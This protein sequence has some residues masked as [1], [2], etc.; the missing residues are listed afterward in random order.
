MTL[1]TRLPDEHGDWVLYEI[2]EDAASVAIVYGNEQTDMWLVVERFYEIDDHY[3]ILYTPDGEIDSNDEI[4]IFTLLSKI[5]MQ[6][7][8]KCRA[9]DDIQPGTAR[10]AY[11]FAGI[12]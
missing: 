7:N 10:D 6:A 4:S 5:R 3:V 11:S 1:R 8:W 9:I 2:D 12:I